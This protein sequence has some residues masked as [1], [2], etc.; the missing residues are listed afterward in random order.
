MCVCSW[1][2][3]P[4][5]KAVPQVLLT[6]LKSAFC[7]VLKQGTEQLMWQWVNQNPTHT[8]TTLKSKQLL[9]ENSESTIWDLKAIHHV[10]VNYDC[11]GLASSGT[12]ARFSGGCTLRRS[13]CKQHAT[14]CL[15]VG[16]N[17]TKTNELL[18]QGQG[19]TMFH[20]QTERV[21]REIFEYNVANHLQKR[22]PIPTRQRQR[23]KTIALKTN[24]NLNDKKYVTCIMYVYI[25]C[26]NRNKRFHRHFLSSPLLQRC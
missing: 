20:F 2:H 22:Q 6:E 11:L 17:D 1:I 23:T 25:T 4:P 24:K 8:L 16:I 10:G 18:V 26:V 14:A 9:V 12:F 15:E 13:S 3:F 5:P 21:C 19:F 7:Q